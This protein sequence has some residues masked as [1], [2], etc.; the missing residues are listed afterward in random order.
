MVHVQDLRVLGCHFCVPVAIYNPFSALLLSPVTG[1]RSVAVSCLCY[2]TPRFIL[3]VWR[4]GKFVGGTGL[5]TA[6]CP[7]AIYD[8]CLCR[9][10]TSH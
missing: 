7:R 5:L 9:R 3:G 10:S 4:E 2:E 6:L 8:C 1:Y